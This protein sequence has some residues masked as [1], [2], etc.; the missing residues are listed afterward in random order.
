MVI[1]ESKLHMHPSQIASQRTPA[2]PFSSGPIRWLSLCLWHHP[3]EGATPS[4]QCQARQLARLR[5]ASRPLEASCRFCCRRHRRN[6]NRQ[7]S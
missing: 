6:F 3:T 4:V 5:W 2:G 1:Y 7:S